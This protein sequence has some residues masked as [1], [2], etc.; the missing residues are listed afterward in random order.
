MTKFFLK[1]LLIKRLLFII[2]GCLLSVIVAGQTLSG[3]ITDTKGQAIPRATIYIKEISHGIIAD[4]NGEFRTTLEKGNYTL[5]VSSL[6]FEK[7]TVSVLIT[8]EGAKMVIE[9]T[10]KLYE[11]NE[12]I[13]TPGKENPAYRIMRNVIARA[14]FHLNQIKGYESDIYLKG[15]FKIDNIPALI[16]SQIKDKEFMSYIGKLLLYESQSEVKYS[17]PDKY[18]LRIIA[19]SSALPQAVSISDNTPLGAVTN[20]IYRPTSFG[21]ILAPG[22]FSLYNFAIEDSYRDIDFVIIAKFNHT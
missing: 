7:K 22:A 14:P 21:G 5:E 9:L 4:E 6:G 18:D 17:E 3:R 15:T 8:E 20:N 2:S 11:L 16:R 10:E 1:Y 13:V 12:V 19:I